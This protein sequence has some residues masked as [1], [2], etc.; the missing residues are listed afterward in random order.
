M[1]IKYLYIEKKNKIIY[2][3]NGRKIK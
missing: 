1:S 3:E 2:S